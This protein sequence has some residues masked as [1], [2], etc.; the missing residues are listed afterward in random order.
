MGEVEVGL[1]FVRM[2][3]WADEQGSVGI[4]YLAWTWDDWPGCDGPTLITDYTGTPTTYG[5]GV[6]DHF[7]SRFHEHPPSRT[8]LLSRRFR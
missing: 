4:G 2:M 6:H 5:Q 8:G 1:I 3:T 7:L